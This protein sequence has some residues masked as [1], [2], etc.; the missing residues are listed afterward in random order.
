MFY[1]EKQEVVYFSTCYM[2]A[3]VEVDLY[4]TTDTPL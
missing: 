4:T 3:L 2:P 1:L